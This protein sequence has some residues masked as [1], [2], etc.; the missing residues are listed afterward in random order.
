MEG[1]LQ[2]LQRILVEFERPQYA[3]AP[4]QSIVFYNNNYCL[5]GGIIESRYNE[6]KNARIRFAVEVNIGSFQQ[7][8]MR[9]AF[10]ERMGIYIVDVVNM[11][12]VE[13]DF[14]EG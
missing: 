5:G 6:N 1:N 11:D 3:I 8:E 9:E 10:D 12:E 13:N 2:I 4:G 14:K 7:G